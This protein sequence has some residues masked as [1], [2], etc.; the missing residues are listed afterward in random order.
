[1]EVKVLPLQRMAGLQPPCAGSCGKDCGG[2][3]GS[4]KNTLGPDNT[5]K[6]STEHGRG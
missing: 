5:E 1:M 3:R 2:K 4:E 6:G